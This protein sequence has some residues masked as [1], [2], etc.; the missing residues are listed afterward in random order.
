MAA[1]VRSY[2]R[3]RGKHGLM[4]PLRAPGEPGRAYQAAKLVRR[5]G[6]RLL[7]QGHLAQDGVS[8]EERTI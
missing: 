5:T 1:L 4:M 3:A 2:L 8:N 7:P 6:D